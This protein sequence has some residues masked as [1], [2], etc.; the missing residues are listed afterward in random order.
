MTVHETE[1]IPDAGDFTDDSPEP[2]SDADLA[3]LC[4]ALQEAG[5]ARAV[6]AYAEGGVND[7]ATKFES[8]AGG[9]VQL[10]T[11]RRVKKDE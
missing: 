1:G 5:V 3:V 8:P 10:M 4:D 7:R 2:A 11:F 6:I 9:K